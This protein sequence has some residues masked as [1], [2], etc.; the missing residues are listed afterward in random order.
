MAT[1]PRL[2]LQLSPAPDIGTPR[3]LTILQRALGAA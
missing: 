2:N 1:E 3:R